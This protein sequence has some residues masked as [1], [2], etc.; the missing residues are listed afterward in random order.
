MRPAS[1]IPKGMTVIST[2]CQAWYDEQ[3]A[4][5]EDAAAQEY[6][7]MQRM[8]R[9]ALEQE[10][11][12]ERVDAHIDADDS[13][14]ALRAALPVAF[15]RRNQGAM[16]TADV[17]YE[18]EPIEDAPREVHVEAAPAPPPDPAPSG[19]LDAPAP[20]TSA[21][22][23]D[24]DGPSVSLDYGPPEPVQAPAHDSVLHR[25]RSLQAAVFGH[26]ST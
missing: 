14:N 4:M 11:Q 20:A 9:R 23:R 24:A 25:L 8:T 26:R 3:W 7:E 1:E 6:S 16:S 10:K 18:P 2:D 21:A 22:P 17:T 13:E 12:A 19:D 15:G 5:E